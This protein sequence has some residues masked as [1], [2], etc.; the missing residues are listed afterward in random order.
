MNIY[1]VIA[2]LVPLLFGISFYLSTEYGYTEVTSDVGYNEDGY[3]TYRVTHVKPA[4]LAN[5]I[6]ISLLMTG[7]LG[8]PILMLIHTW[9]DDRKL[10]KERDILYR[11]AEDL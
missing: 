10:K 7:L 5:S 2:I 11:K 3:Y 4:T 9:I 1:V 6:I 8:T